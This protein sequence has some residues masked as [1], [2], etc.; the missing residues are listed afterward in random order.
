M[1]L[2]SNS[3]SPILMKTDE[4]EKQCEFQLRFTPPSQ[5]KMFPSASS[6]SYKNIP[7]FGIWRFTKKK[8]ARRKVKDNLA[9]WWFLQYVVMFTPQ[10]LG[11]ISNLTRIC[12]QMGCK[13]PPISLTVRKQVCLA[14]CRWYWFWLS[15]GHV[16][17]RS[18]DFLVEGS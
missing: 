4:K 11:K 18:V 5:H 14:E 6:W 10:K 9:R 7:S 13:K 8:F 2:G 3:S 16:L 17:T 12:F 15:L 1:L